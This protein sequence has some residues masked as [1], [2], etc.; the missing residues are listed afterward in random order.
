MTSKGQVC[1]GARESGELRAGSLCVEMAA[2]VL[3]RTV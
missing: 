3:L 2:H 1:I